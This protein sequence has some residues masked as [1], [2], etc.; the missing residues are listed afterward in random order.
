VIN[1][2]SLANLTAE[3]ITRIEQK[4]TAS[5]KHAKVSALIEQWKATTRLK[6]RLLDLD[7]RFAE[8]AE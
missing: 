7:T 5:K 6:Q 1:T 2:N 3:E 8:N 4:L